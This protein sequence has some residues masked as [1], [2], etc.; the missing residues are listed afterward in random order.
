[1]RMERIGWAELW[2]AITRCAMLV[3]RG[4]CLAV[5]RVALSKAK[6]SRRTTSLDT[7]IWKNHQ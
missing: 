3:R 5:F 1:M 2:L 7:R 6:S 4:G